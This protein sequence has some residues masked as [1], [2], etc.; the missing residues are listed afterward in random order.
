MEAT[1]IQVHGSQYFSPSYCD[2]QRVASLGYQIQESMKLTPRDAL[3]IG[4]GCGI[5]SALL[6]AGVWALVYMQIGGALFN[7]AAAW[8]L[9]PWCPGWFRG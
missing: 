7:T 5:V 4:V 9:C 1:G 6:G 8:L 2:P 3:E